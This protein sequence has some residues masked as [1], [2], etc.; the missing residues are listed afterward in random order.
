MSKRHRDSS[1]WDDDDDYTPTNKKGKPKAKAKSKTTKKTKT[2]GISDGPMK[3][4][5]KK[6]DRLYDKWKSKTADAVKGALAMNEICQAG[7]KADVVWRAVY[8]Q[9]LGS[10]EACPRCSSGRVKVIVD[11]HGNPVGDG[12]TV[13]YKCPGQFD[14]ETNTYAFCNKKYE[15]HELK[16]APWQYDDD[17]EEDDE[18]DAIDDSDDDEDDASESDDGK[19]KPRK[20]ATKAKAKIKAGNT[21]TSSNSS[22]K[23]KKAKRNASDDDD[24][25]GTDASIPR[26]SGGAPP[27]CRYGASCYRKNPEHLKEFSHPPTAAPV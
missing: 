10:P 8:G 23:K 24:D 9:I 22:A 14:V 11:A 26:P 25:S 19:K 7:N 16:H 1:S 20:A 12:S 13:Y 21:S 15:Y 6:M 4:K 17:D 5:R 3:G 18:K 27:P 2:K